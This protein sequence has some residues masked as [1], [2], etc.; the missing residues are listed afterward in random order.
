[1]G[2]LLITADWHLR[3]TD[4]AWAG[5]PQ[6]RGDGAFGLTEILRVLHERQGEIDAVVV[7][8]DLFDAKVQS[9]DAIELFRSFAEELH[10]AALPLYFVQ[11]Q[12][13]LSSPPPAAAI[14]PATAIHIDGVGFDWGGRFVAGLDYRHPGEV[15]AALAAVPASASLLITHQVWRDFLGEARGHAWAGW[16]PCPL[17]VSG[18]YHVSVDAQP[19]PLP[20]SADGHLWSP[21]PLA[22]QSVSESPEKSV[23]L[24][25]EGLDFERVPVRCRKIFAATV[26][27]E[28][29]LEALVD[30]ANV[31]RVCAP[32]AGVPAEVAVPLYRI[33]IDPDLPDAAERIQAAFA[34]KAH[35]FFTPISR[36]EKE[37]AALG[38][39]P[40]P[41]GT[42]LEEAV[43]AEARDRGLPAAAADDALRLLAAASRG[44]RAAKEAASALLAEPVGA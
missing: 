34:G 38:Q 26:D 1:M 7:A 16:C 30:K 24:L 32:Q 2:K 44:G 4:A 35:L 3:R 19:F 9:S 15:E 21:G 28:A 31:D 13:E 43:R 27:H 14:H 17:I 8:G 41:A 22:P 37:A 25:D 5:R 42:T 33:K 39:S 10:R 12:H 18:D 29:T 40:T 20:S 23:L 36:R 6:I 11:G